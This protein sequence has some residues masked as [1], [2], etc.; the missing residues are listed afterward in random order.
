MKIDFYLP[1]KVK[2]NKEYTTLVRQQKELDQHIK[3]LTDYIHRLENQYDK[4]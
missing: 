3:N 4:R 1:D 2:I